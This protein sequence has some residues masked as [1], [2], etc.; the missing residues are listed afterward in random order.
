VE[1]SC[2]ARENRRSV[3]TEKKNSD[4]VE[5]FSCKVHAVDMEEAVLRSGDFIEKKTFHMVVTL[6]T[7]MVMQAQKD[8]EFKAIL[9]EVDLVVPDSAGICWACRRAGT[10]LKGRV[11]GID[12][13]Q[14][15]AALAPGRNWRL[16]FLG[17]APGV[18]EEAAAALS[19]KIPGFFVA[20]SFHGYFKDDAEA[21]ERIREAKP[22]I[23][24]AAL[25]SPRQEKWLWN[26]R[27]RLPVAV[28]IGVGGS[29]DVL[30]GRRRRAPSW[31]QKTGL[32]WLHRLLS[33][34]SRCGRM[35]AL[36]AFVH[37]VLTRG[38]K[39]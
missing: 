33:E 10:P 29:L 25:G 13:L 11:P 32:E 3:E 22:D 5:L 8:G 27:E 14:R 37:M 26:N 7:E 15:L 4:C 23:L 30:S 36:P 1:D 9:N 21:I 35:R 18:A 20:G 24:V 2:D 12:L 17:S 31:M 38:V 19:E 28:A 39:T 34:P 6:G 16:F